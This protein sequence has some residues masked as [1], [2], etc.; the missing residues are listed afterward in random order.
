M[1]EHVGLQAKLSRDPDEIAQAERLIL[2]GV[3]AWDAGC[4]ALQDRGLA[5]PIREAASQGTPILGICLGMQLLAQ[6]SEEGSMQG[7]GLVDAEF[8]RF[9]ADG[10]NPPLK[11]PHIG[12]N[13]VAPRQDHPLFA[14]FEKPGRF[15]FVHSYYAHGVPPAESMATTEYGVQFASAYGKG[16][17][18]GVQFHPEKSHVNGMRLLKNFAAVPRGS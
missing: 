1:L 11:V 16:N 12:W 10:A 9:R 14:G 7:L 13:Y 6:R 8:K 17:V 4:R 3:G 5:E 15:Y 18:M 2:P